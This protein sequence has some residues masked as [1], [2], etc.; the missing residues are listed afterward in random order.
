MRKLFFTCSLLVSLAGFANEVATFEDSRVINKSFEVGPGVEI[1]VSNKYGNVVIEK[2]PADSVKVRVEISAFSE[3]LN[4]LEDLMSMA[5]IRFSSGDD[6]V[7]METLWG[8]NAGAW[9]KG[10]T[11][12]SQFLGGN[13]R[14]QINYWIV[15]PEDAELEITNKFGDIKLPS[16]EEDLRVTLS[17]GSLYA[18]NIKKFKRL[19]VSY[20]KL[21]IKSIDKGNMDLKFTDLKLDKA[22][23]ITVA[24]SSGD[25]EIEE[26]DDL[27]FTIKHGKAEIES[28]GD[29]QITSI[30]S[31]VEI[32]QLTGNL[33]G[34]FKYGEL[35]LDEVLTSFSGINLSVSL[36]SVD[37]DFHPEIAFEYNIQLN[38]GKGL[39]LPTQHNDIANRTN[40]DKNETINGT[41]STIPMRTEPSVVVITGKYSSISLDLNE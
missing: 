21:N 25:I 20:G 23:K 38:H 14:I 2:G 24:A 22:K 12:I 15:V 31:E 37:I 36:A 4:K 29:I 7:D 40:F 9:K 13:N 3:R 18:R 34:S 6:Y 5:D 19:D 30:M 8:G 28:A 16:L 17:H 41:V 26:V 10:M 35:S 11:D 33:V 32:E 39:N 1:E 27:S